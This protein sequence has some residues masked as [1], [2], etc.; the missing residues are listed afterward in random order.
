MYVLN[1][2]DI[3]EIQI[4][5]RLHG[6][7]TRNTFHYYIATASPIADG[8]A[9]LTTL[10]NSFLSPVYEKILDFQSDDWTCSAVTVQKVSTT[11]MRLI[12][13][14][15]S[16]LIGNHSGLSCPST[17]AAVVS[18]YCEEAGRSFQGRIF[19]PGVPLNLEENSLVNEEG[20]ELLD[21]VATALKAT[22]TISGG[23]DAIPTLS[24]G[25]HDPVTQRVVDATAS[26]KLRVQRRREVG[27]GS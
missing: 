9:A 8:K 24:K 22:I 5:G 2:K 25:A 12:K 1:D 21:I 19:I 27:L 18:R 7:E 10:V 20:M 6:Q 16:D 4:I 15:P 11:R 13:V 17:T 26:D 23:V 3:A 14:T